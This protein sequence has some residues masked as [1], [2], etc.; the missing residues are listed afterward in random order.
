[1]TDVVL[2]SPEIPPNTGNSIRLC[3]NV[4]AT[5]HLIEPLGF[6]LDDKN[7]KRAGLDYHDLTHVKTHA[8]W[9]DFLKT[10]SPDQRCFAFTTSATRRYDQVDWQKNDVILFGQE[11]K[12][13]P[14]AVLDYFDENHRIYLPMM[15][16]NRSVNLSNTV[17][18]ACYEIWRQCAFSID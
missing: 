11:T 18:V 10:L 13:L 12:G 4:G 2:F 17:A 6:S 1:M 15:P 7:L 9:A 5:L 16:G 14:A 3:A 8:S